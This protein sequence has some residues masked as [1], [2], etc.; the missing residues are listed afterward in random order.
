MAG[1]KTETVE[2]TAI[3]THAEIGRMLGITPS[4][5]RQF[6]Q[7]AIRKL[8]ERLLA[9]RFDPKDYERE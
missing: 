4:A 1:Q 8:R 3:R 5:V 6:E 7:K 9:I 2:D